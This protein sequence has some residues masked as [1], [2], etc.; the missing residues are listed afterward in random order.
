M[1]RSGLATLLF[2]AGA[3]C[4]SPLTGFAVSKSDEDGY[5]LEIEIRNEGTQDLAFAMGP[6][7]LRLQ[8][9]E[10]GTGNPLPVPVALPAPNIEGLVLK[11]GENFKQDFVLDT[12]I[13]GLKPTLARTDV[14]LSW[15][16]D[17]EATN[18]CITLSARGSA[19]LKH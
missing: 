15:V 17:L 4:Q 9:V 18:G 3:Q 14:R 7:T 19:L 16:L 12:L 6:N 1:P 10:A 13:L 8:A 11:P 5:T 2:L